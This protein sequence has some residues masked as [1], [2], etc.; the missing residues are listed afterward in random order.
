M[1][2]RFTFWLQNLIK[3]HQQADLVEHASF[4]SEHSSLFVVQW[5]GTYVRTQ[6]PGAIWSRK[7]LTPEVVAGSP[8]LSQDTSA[9]SLLL[10]DFMWTYQEGVV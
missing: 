4:H 6:K 3:S 9:H 8:V 1:I 7:A 2:A 5:A 10:L